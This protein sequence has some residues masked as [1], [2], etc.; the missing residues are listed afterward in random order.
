MWQVIL[1]TLAVDVGGLL[2]IYGILSARVRRATSAA[3][4]VSEL[5]EEIDRLVVEL[6]QTA[7]RNIA[8]IEDRIASLNELAAVADKRIGL[9]RREIEKHDVGAQLYAR[10]GDARPSRSTM[11]APSVS[12]PAPAAPVSPRPHPF[13]HRLPPFPRP[14]PRRCLYDRCRCLYARR[15]S[16]HGRCRHLRQSAGPLPIELSSRSLGEPDLRQRVLMLHRAGF[17]SALIATR[18][19]APRGEIELIIALEERKT[20]PRE[21]E[22]EREQKRGAGEAARRP[23]SDEGEM[24]PDQRKAAS[25]E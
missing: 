1:I 17:S 11:A 3:S 8:L 13:P 5:R 23:V 20:A 6:N 10:L 7:D 12:Q 22:R 4:Q 19:G 14:R 9:L 18:V 24:A 16:L 25:T 21:H 15:R 2:L